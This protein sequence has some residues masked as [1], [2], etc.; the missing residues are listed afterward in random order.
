V[1]EGENRLSR[2]AAARTAALQSE[3]AALRDRLDTLLAELDRRRLRARGDLTKVRRYGLP[4]LGA[5][6]LVGAVVAFAR[7]RG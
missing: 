3:A 7:A 6:I 2:D 1:D 4:L 5:L